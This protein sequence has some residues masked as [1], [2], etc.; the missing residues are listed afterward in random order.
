MDGFESMNDI[1]QLFYRDMFEVF[2]TE[3]SRDDVLNT[4]SRKSARFFDL[5]DLTDAVWEREKMGSTFFGN[6]IAAPHPMFAVSASDTFIAI[7]VSPQPITWDASGNKVNL[8]M[9]VNVSKNNSKAFQIWN[10]LSKLFAHR[11]FVTQL[12][13]D[14]SYEHFLKLLKDTI[15]EN[16]TG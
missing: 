11:E 16:F 12:L 2:R 15:A 3:V 9:L 8:V 14:P 13:Q 5:P 7:G 4:L 6:G 10:Y 1:L